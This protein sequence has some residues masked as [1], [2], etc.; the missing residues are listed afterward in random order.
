MQATIAIFANPQN[1]YKVFQIADLAQNLKSCP[2]FKGVCNLPYVPYYFGEH[3]F[4]EGDVLNINK[5]HYFSENNNG[6]EFKKIKKGSQVLWEIKLDCT[7]GWLK[8]H[9]LGSL[10]SE[11]FSDVPQAVIS[12][13][14]QQKSR[15]VWDKK[16]KNGKFRFKNGFLHLRTNYY[17]VVKCPIW[18]KILKK[19]NCSVRTAFLD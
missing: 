1:N 15:G 9:E 7:R 6:V 12:F 11:L 18:K 8:N 19:N 14:S 2:F 16:E 13:S 5:F 4:Y 3:D 10:I 17:G